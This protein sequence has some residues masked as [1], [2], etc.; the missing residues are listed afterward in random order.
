MSCYESNSKCNSEKA[1]FCNFLEDSKATSS[2]YRVRG[3]E[4]GQDEAAHGA[5]LTRVPLGN[6]IG[7]AAG[8]RA[9]GRAGGTI[10]E[11]S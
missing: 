10:H 2:K 3:G 11:E 6:A 4:D 5:L 8:G 1:E 7:I 9:G